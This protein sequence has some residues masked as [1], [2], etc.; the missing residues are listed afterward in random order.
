MARGWRRP[1]WPGRVRAARTSLVG[2]CES[3]YGFHHMFGS[4][5]LPIA[6][7]YIYCVWDR[8]TSRK[9]V[10]PNTPNLLFASNDYGSLLKL[11][12]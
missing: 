3:G 12:K 11:I 5:G 10:A 4:L 6:F 1:G 9:K 8:S 2:W 7:I